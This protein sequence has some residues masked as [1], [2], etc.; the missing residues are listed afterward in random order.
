M[1]NQIAPLRGRHPDVEVVL[2]VHHLGPLHALVTASHRADL[3]V[4]GSWGRGGFHG[5]ALGSTTHKLLYLTGCP[6]AVVN[7]RPD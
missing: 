7:A 4:V 1:E 6:T 2:D 5:L 3:L